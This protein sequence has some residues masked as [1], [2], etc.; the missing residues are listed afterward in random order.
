M[1]LE[2]RF[3]KLQMGTKV[4]L[5]LYKK[6]AA[7]VAQGS[8][9]FDTLNSLQEKYEKNKKGDVRASV[10]RYWLA[11]MNSG[12]TFSEAID[13]WVPNTERMLIQAGEQSGSLEEA[14]LNAVEVTEATNTMKSTIMGALSYPLVLFG[15]LVAMVMLFSTK[16]IPTLTAVLKPEDWP[17]VSKPLYAISQWV[18]NYI[19]YAALGIVAVGIIL[20]YS[21]SR[22]SGPMR[23]KFKFMPPYSIYHSFNG[24]VFLV[25]L[26]SLMKTGTPMNDALLELEE[27]A[28]PFMSYYLRTMLVRMNSG[29]SSGST[30]N[31][32][33]LSK[34][35][36]V[37]VEIYDETN[38]FQSSMEAIGKSAIEQGIESIKKGSQVI[39]YILLLMVTGYL[40]YT[41][42]AFF[43]LTQS[44]AG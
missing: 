31:C 36:S 12:M 35:I 20:G 30:L 18:E 44:I 25:S 22:W 41:Y 32:G 40:G 28:N 3:Y 24:S 29:E 23:E 27:S 21:L 8:P 4:R 15:V 11:D 10:I 19:L 38:D 42:Y 16:V 39:F 14:M 6:L 5:E 1:N 43:T 37:E 33:L 2:Q 26:A 17:E 9:L 34:E 7:F 13:G